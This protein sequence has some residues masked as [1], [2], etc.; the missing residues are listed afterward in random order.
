MQCQAFAFPQQTSVCFVPTV[1]VAA[2]IGLRPFDSFI[3]PTFRLVFAAFNV[4]RKIVNDKISASASHE[5]GSLVRLIRTRHCVRF[6]SNYDIP[7]QKLYVKTI[8]RNHATPVDLIAVFGK[9]LQTIDHFTREP[10]RPR[11]ATDRKTKTMTAAKKYTI[12]MEKK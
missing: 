7:K 9:N 4:V 6:T 8:F 10:C 5:N 2:I 1:R 11:N 12:R 3:E